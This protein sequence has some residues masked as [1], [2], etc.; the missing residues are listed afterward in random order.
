MR[1]MMH[2]SCNIGSHT[3]LLSEWRKRTINGESKTNQG[4]DESN[5]N[6]KDVEL[7]VTKRRCRKNE[8]RR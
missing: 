7:N 3:N 8:S 5:V 4:Y 1:K 6:Q 2:C